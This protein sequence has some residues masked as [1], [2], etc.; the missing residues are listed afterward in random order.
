M[1]VGHFGDYRLKALLRRDM[2]SGRVMN[3]TKVALNAVR[4]ADV[5]VIILRTVIG[6]FRHIIKLRQ[7]AHCFGCFQDHRLA[8]G[9]ARMRA[10]FE[11][12]D[13]QALTGKHTRKCRTADSRSNNCHIILL[14]GFI[15]E[16]FYPLP[17]RFSM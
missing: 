1:A 6:E 10:P 16:L 13:R 9:K 14:I 4:G 8:D 3:K 5:A 15:H 2:L 17:F 7:G 12:D 11:Y